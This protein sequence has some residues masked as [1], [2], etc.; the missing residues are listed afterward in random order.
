VPNRRA[1]PHCQ[2]P[3]V[4]KRRIATRPE[5][6]RC[7]SP[8]LSTIRSRRARI[9][10]PSLRS[11]STRFSQAL[12]FNVHRFIEGQFERL[13]EE[14]RSILEAAS[15]DGDRFTIAAVAAGT[16]SPHDRVEARCVAL[17]RTHGVLTF[18]GMTVWRH[19]TH[20]V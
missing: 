14:D 9:D 3:L 10:G 17:A 2:R 1:F 12:P 6:T 13:P 19:G 15:V 16:S 7:F 5:A 18:D 11:I 4:G 8:P 20:G